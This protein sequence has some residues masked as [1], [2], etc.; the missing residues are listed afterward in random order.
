[1]TTAGIGV[2]EAPVAEVKRDEQRRE[3]SGK[4]SLNGEDSLAEEQSLG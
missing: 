1:M 2:A 4:R 3:K